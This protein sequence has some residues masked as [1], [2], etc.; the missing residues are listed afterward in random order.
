MIIYLV[1]TTCVR[2]LPQP[3]QMGP[4]RRLLLVK[5][6]IILSEMIRKNVIIVL[7]TRFLNVGC[8]CCSKRIIILTTAT[9]DHTKIAK[10]CVCCDVGG[11][12]IGR[13]HRWPGSSIVVMRWLLLSIVLHWTRSC[14]WPRACVQLSQ[15]GRTSKWING[16]FA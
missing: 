4:W 1:L 13:T 6:G 7:H 12:I 8:R 16:R 9:V 14:R 2:I 11:Q 15:I 5:R 3:N 10:S